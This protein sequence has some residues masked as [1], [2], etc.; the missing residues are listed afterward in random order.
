MMFA[1]RETIYNNNYRNP[2]IYKDNLPASGVS[3]PIHNNKEVGPEAMSYTVVR[4]G[5]GNTVSA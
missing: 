5:G 1:A 4:G 3:N 2:I